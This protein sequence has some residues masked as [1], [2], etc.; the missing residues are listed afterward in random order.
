MFQ[1]NWNSLTEEKSLNCLEILLLVQLLTSI[2]LIDP[3]LVLLE[4]LVPNKLHSRVDQTICFAEGSL[5][6][7][8]PTRNPLGGNTLERN[9][10]IGTKHIVQPTEYGLRCLQVLFRN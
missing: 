1:P 3:L 2:H 8:E 7:S 9:R 6:Y 10:L 5:D 4:H